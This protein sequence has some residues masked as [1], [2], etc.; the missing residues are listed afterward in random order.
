MPDGP[1]GSMPHA[2]LRVTAMNRGAVMTAAFPHM[3]SPHPNANDPK[4]R[5]LLREAHPSPDLPPRF[6]EGVWQRLER[7]GW[8]RQ[9][10]VSN[11]W[12]AALVRMMFRPAYATIGLVAVMVAGVW[13]GVRDGETQLHRAEKARYVAAVSPFH[14]AVP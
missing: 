11:T 13:L 10:S 2:L 5:A 8:R 7:A 4:L 14:R 1:K 3:N 9:E 6:Q 12:I